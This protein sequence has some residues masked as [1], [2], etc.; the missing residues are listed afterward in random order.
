MLIPRGP[1]VYF[2]SFVF[3][4]IRSGKAR[5]S[6]EAVFRVPIFLNKLDIK[7][8]LERLYGLRV[9]DVQTF[10]FLPKVT[11]RGR[12]YIPGKKNAIVRLAEGTFKYPPPTDPALLKFPLPDNNV[13][14]KLH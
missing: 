9:A 6:N 8:Y 12:N 5:A 3:T 4:L 11:R 13:Y 14:P 10:I 7:Q 1:K 2:P